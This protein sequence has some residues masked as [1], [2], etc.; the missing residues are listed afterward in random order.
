VCVCVYVTSSN[1]QSRNWTFY[2]GECSYAEQHGAHIQ[3]TI[4]RHILAIPSYF[5]VK[6]FHL[7]EV[8]RHWL[9]TL[10]LRP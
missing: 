6:E 9:F 8:L 10:I 1:S 7:L 4:F 5:R 3:H 2:R